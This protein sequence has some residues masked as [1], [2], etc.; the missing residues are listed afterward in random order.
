MAGEVQLR[1][2]SSC[3][4]YG[5]ASASARLS[6]SRPLSLSISLDRPTELTYPPI[7]RAPQANLI[8]RSEAES[9]LLKGPLSLPPPS[10]SPSTAQAPA[11]APS[12]H[13]LPSLATLTFAYYSGAHLG[14][15]FLLGEEKGVVKVVLGVGAV[16]LVGV[17]GGRS[18]R[19]IG[20]LRRG[21]VGGGGEEVVVV[22]LERGEGGGGG[23]DA[24]R[25]GTAAA[26]GGVREDRSKVKVRIQVLSVEEWR[27]AFCARVFSFVSSSLPFSPFFPLHSSL[28]LPSSSLP[29]LPSL[30]FPLPLFSP[31]LSPSLSPPPLSL[32]LSPHPQADQPPSQPN[33]T[34]HQPIAKACPSFEF[35]ASPV[36][37]SSSSS[38]FAASNGP[39]DRED[40]DDSEDW[41]HLAVARMWPGVE[42][43]GEGEE[44]EEEEGEGG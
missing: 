36:P 26:A 19:G 13:R 16:G 3:F 43:E 7:N 1:R 39:S 14:T 29:P 44:E 34:L 20:S 6:F 42:E 23:M 38:S 31:S 18:S 30:P 25:F 21:G 35:G 9:L 17:V 32:S 22:R 33:S 27:G 4:F 12:I 8:T 37:S 24:M 15:R 10:S 11:P 28:L 41:L 2:L 5:S 40:E